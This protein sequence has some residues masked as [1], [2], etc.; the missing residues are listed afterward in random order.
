MDGRIGSAVVPNSTRLALTKRALRILAPRRQVVAELGRDWH[1]VNDTVFRYGEALVDVTGHLENVYAL[2]LDELSSCAEAPI[3][4]ASSQARSRT[5]KRA[6]SSTSSLVE[7]PEARVP[8]LH[9]QDLDFC[10]RIDWA[11]TDL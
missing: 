1:T 2:G 10:A 9:D 8:W 11:T 7:V 6:N 4:G 5:S 3:I